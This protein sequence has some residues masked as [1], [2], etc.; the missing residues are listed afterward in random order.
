MQSVDLAKMSVENQFPPISFLFRRSAMERI[1]LFDGTL[2]V[3]GDWDFHLRMARRYQ[4]DVIPEPLAYYHHRT[5]GTTNHYGNTVIA[6]KSV[7]QIQRAHYIN[8]GM[9][10]ALDAPMDSTS[11]NLLYQGELH[12]EVSEGISEIRHHLHWLEKML[13]DRADHSAYLEKIIKRIDAKSN[14]T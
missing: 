4:I 8:R 3:L 1:G 10:A 14:N 12:R 9:R 5:A 13:T 11:G 7:H 2:P 6:Q